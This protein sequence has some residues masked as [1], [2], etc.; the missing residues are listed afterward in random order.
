M[1][2]SKLKPNK[3]YL[4]KHTIQSSEKGSISFVMA[5]ESVRGRNSV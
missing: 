1:M 2:E 5:Y 3:S 4:Y